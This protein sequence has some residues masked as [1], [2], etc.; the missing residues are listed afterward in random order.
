[1]QMDFLLLFPNSI[2]LSSDIYPV[3]IDMKIFLACQGRKWSLN[4]FC[5]TCQTRVALSTLGVASHEP[6]FTLKQWRHLFDK[7]VS[8][9]RA[10]IKLDDIE[11]FMLQMNA[12]VWEKIKTIGFYYLTKMRTKTTDIV[13]YMHPYTLPSSAG[14]WR[15]QGEETVDED[16]RKWKTTYQLRLL[17]D[18]QGAEHICYVY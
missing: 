11:I 12:S 18:G 1:M 2:S 10:K 5:I 9:I 15:G 3:S 13:L 16:C 17:V 6:Q 4:R 8:T 14:S 7:C